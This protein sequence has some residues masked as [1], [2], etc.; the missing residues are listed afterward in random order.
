MCPFILINDY[1]ILDTDYSNVSLLFSDLHVIMMS[2]SQCLGIY[3][4]QFGSYRHFKLQY[5]Y[6]QTNDNAPSGSEYHVPMFY[7][8]LWVQFVNGLRLAAITMPG[9]FCDIVM[10]TNE[11]TG[12]LPATSGILKP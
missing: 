12:A 6:K 11:K 4:T 8:R 5:A 1:D 10:D 3:R 2:T 7:S 9:L